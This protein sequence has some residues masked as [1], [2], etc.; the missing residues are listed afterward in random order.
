MSCYEQEGKAATNE[1]RQAD[2]AVLLTFECVRETF[3]KRVLVL[4]R[5]RTNHVCGEGCAGTENIEVATGVTLY[6]LQATVST[7][8][9]T[10]GRTIWL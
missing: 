3:A 10:V 1:R 6:R 2:T 8:R 5:V 9:G 7:R 4:R